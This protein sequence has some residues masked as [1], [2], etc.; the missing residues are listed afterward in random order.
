MSFLLK[1]QT[2]SALIFF[3][4]LVFAF[5]APTLGN[6]FVY[7]DHQQIEQN[8]Y[9]QSLQYLPKIIT[10]C[11]WEGAFGSCSERGI[12]YYRP[13]QSLAYLV[14]FQFSSHAFIFHLFNV[15][16]FLIATFLVFLLARELS[17][18]TLC[19]FFA[20]LI[21]LVHPLNSEAIN[22]IS[23]TPELL[24]AVFV[25]AAALFYCRDRAVPLAPN[26]SGLFLRK[27]FLLSLFFYFLAILAKEPA[28]LLPVLFVAFDLLIFKISLQRLWKWR[29][30]QRYG[31]YAAMFFL[32]MALRF[33][34]LGG[35]APQGGF[36]ESF[37]V[38]ERIYAFFTL[39]AQYSEK[40]LYP[41]PLLF[42]YTFEQKSD[43]ASMVFLAAL[44]VVAAFFA[45]GGIAW[46]HGKALVAI[47]FLWMFVFLLPVLVFLENLN[48]AIFAE[49]YVFVPAIGLAFAASWALARA[50]QAHPK[51]PFV[52]GGI[53]CVLGIASFAIAQERNAQWKDDETL[54]L[55]TLA[56]NERSYP[57]R[58]NW[59]VYLRN[60]KNDFEAAKKEFETI[61]AQNPT[62]R[63]NSLVYL[64][65]G[66]WARDVEKNEEHA[67]A[68]YEKSVEV[69]QDWKASFAYDRLG[70]LHAARDE[71][72]NAV[73]YFCRATQLGGP[74]TQ[75]NEE[76]LG[77]AIDLSVQR[78][79]K[80]L[81]ELYGDVTN[82]SV[83]QKSERQGVRYN[84]TTCQ[85]DSCSLFFFLDGGNEEIIL[86]L[87]IA[88]IMDSG[89]PVTIDNMAR[90]P[91]GD[92]AML[93]VDA[94]YKDEQLTFIFPTCGGA[95]YEAATS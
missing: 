78:Y 31:A 80:N 92:Q 82:N 89:K 41:L 71:F 62:W 55:A 52:V 60:E 54:Y 14:A 19:A 58:F 68:L 47:G 23:S 59:A 77:R 51:A 50:W 25:L 9:L 38:G 33:A 7:D 45:I 11:T 64:H 91:Q 5:Y 85:E 10:G 8:E 12:A 16:Y 73:P 3:A 20:G 39:L 26:F 84:R 83:F 57:I 27:T 53:L 32:Y 88:G 28:A 70:S 61:L 42:Y 34:A 43:F 1:H 95:Y 79:E 56:V 46:R 67:I 74:H 44:A 81:A 87:L 66:D 90:S 75:S 18:N 4:V 35:I 21:F 6:G 36:Y 13:M 72:L 94:R 65:L 48:E 24:F 76:R 40:F 63:D 29:E 69:A 93:E 37:S 15:F 49:R 86:P 17:K 30:V 22:W 2:S